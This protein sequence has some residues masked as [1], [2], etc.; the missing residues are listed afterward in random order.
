SQGTQECAI[1][2][3]AL[4]FSRTT[5]ISASGTS[6][7]FSCSAVVASGSWDQEWRDSGGASSPTPMFGGTHTIDGTWGDWVLT[8]RDDDPAVVIGV[9]QLTVDPGG[10]TDFSQCPLVGLTRLRMVGAIVFQ[11]P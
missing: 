1:S 11:D 7:E 8:I 6:T 9:A 3:D 4:E 5:D 10:A 2:L